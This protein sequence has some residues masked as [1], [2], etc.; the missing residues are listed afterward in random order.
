MNHT[1]KYPKWF[2]YHLRC[3]ALGVDSG[4]FCDILKST[5]PNK[6][7]VGYCVILELVPLFGVNEMSSH[8]HKTLYLYLEP[9]WFLLEISDE[10]PHSFYR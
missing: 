4:S 5:E 9:L 2:W 1:I 3:S 6:V 10:H 8:A 7:S